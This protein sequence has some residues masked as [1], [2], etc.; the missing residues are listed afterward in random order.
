MNK[1]CVKCQSC[2]DCNS[3]T[4]C[5][6]CQGCKDCIHNSILNNGIKSSKLFGKQHI[7]KIIEQ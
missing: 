7:I 6:D 4:G 2:S 3:C 1:E 5:K